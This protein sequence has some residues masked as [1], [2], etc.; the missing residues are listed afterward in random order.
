MTTAAL[1]NQFSREL[2][3]IEKHVPMTGSFQR[4]DP[5]VIHITAAPVAF[6]LIVYHIESQIWYD[7]DRSRHAT[8]DIRTISQNLLPRPGEVAFDLGSNAGFYSLA[9]AQLVGPAGEIHA[10]D[11]FPWNAAA[12]RFNARLNGLMNVHMHQVGIGGTRRR[13]KDRVQRRAHLHAFPRRIWD[14]HRPA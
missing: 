10:F 6:D 3:K 4:I 2:D 11:P 9:F 12:V 7:T 13:V 8:H 5:Y 14:R 1:L